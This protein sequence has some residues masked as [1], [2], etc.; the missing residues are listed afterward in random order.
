VSSAAR[1][2]RRQV[3]Q[4][5]LAALDQLEALRRIAMGGAPGGGSPSATPRALSLRERQP[6]IAGS[7]AS[8]GG[9]EGGGGEVY[10]YTPSRV[11]V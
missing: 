10:E 8:G 11:S 6:S 1:S 7:V 5:A 2:L 4:R 3:E 9:Y